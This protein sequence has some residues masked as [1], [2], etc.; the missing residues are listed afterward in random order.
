MP[1]SVFQALAGTACPPVSRAPPVAALTRSPVAPAP[2]RSVS[3]RTWSP[4]SSTCSNKIHVFECLTSSLPGQD[5]QQ[6]RSLL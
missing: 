2:S 1:P 6:K 4:A 3:D 5:F